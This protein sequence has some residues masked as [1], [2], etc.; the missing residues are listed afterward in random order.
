MHVVK[1]NDLFILDQHEAHCILIL[2]YNV[3]ITA[4]RL[5]NY[6]NEC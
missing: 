3:T 6:F 1:I 4:F 5:E 2:I